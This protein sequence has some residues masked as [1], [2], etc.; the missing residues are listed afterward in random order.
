MSHR[1]T[2]YLTPKQLF[3]TLICTLNKINYPNLP[4]TP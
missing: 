3:K 4:Q 2:L 1:L